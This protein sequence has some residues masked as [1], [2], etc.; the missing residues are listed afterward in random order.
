MTGPSAI[1]ALWRKRLGLREP[2]IIDAE[3]V[4]LSANGVADFDALHSRIDDEKAVD[5]A[6]DLLLS[7]DDIRRLPLIECKK[8]L[9]SVLRD[10]RGGIQYVE[11]TEGN[12]D[13]MFKAVCRLAW[14]A[15]SQR[16]SMRR[17][18]RDHQRRGKK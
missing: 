1:L 3:V 18:S 12:G 17:T 8:A 7:G 2:L 14:K 15:L 4:H 5:L 16:N 10:S 9:R 13:E 11:H 6:F